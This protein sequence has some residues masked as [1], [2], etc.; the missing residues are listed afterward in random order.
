[1]IDIVDAIESF[2]DWIKRETAITHVDVNYYRSEAKDI[3]CLVVYSGSQPNAEGNHWMIDID[4][5][6]RI[7]ATA[8]RY[9]EVLRLT[10]ELVNNVRQELRN[11][12]IIRDTERVGSAE[13]NTSDEFGTET[14]FRLCSRTGFN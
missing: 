3:R 7:T 8:D 13:G 2:A 12:V 5:A 11:R 9:V 10:Q 1:M 6:V 4:V 14:S